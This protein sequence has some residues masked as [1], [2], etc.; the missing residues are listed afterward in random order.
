MRRGL[1]ALAAVVLLAGCGFDKGTIEAG[2][3]I[4]GPNLTIYSSLPQPGRGLSRDIVDAEKLAIA[5]A[6]GKAGDF[7][8]NFV[9]INEGPPGRDAP[10]K[11]VGIATEQVIHDPQVIGVIGTLRSDTALTSVPLFNAAGILQVTLGAEYPG[12]DSAIAPG[13]PERWFPSGRK[14]F[15]RMAGNDL[16]QAPVLAG[17]GKR[18]AIESE[19]GKVSQALA[20]AVRD[21]AGDKLV[22]DPARADAIVYAGTDV[23]SAVGVAESLA[24][25]N[26]RA[27][28]V[29]PVELT[30]A[31]IA[32]RLPP[33]VLRR[34]VFATSA[35]ERDADFEAA[36]KQHFGRTPDPY[37]LL[38]YQAMQR[39]LQAI[40][41]AGGRA[42]LRSVVADRYFQLPPVN[43]A[44]RLISSPASRRR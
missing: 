27:K 10:A 21:A 5:E 40:D 38:G 18:I 39:V 35:P 43:H 30:R 20:D 2:G 36:F 41:D 34:A 37:A 17:A 22:D 29:F 25:E 3:R 42:H 24:R 12:F 33:R 31:G 14:T 19:A 26:P 32:D 23:R 16:D 4:N 44:F 7:G 1:A 9:S 11:Q 15:G 13:E 8:I 6:G 28:I